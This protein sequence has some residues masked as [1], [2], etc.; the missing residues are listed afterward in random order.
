MARAI[1][2]YSLQLL[3]FSEQSLPLGFG[4]PN[5]PLSLISSVSCYGL[6]HQLILQLPQCPS[7]FLFL[8]VPLV[9]P[10]LAFLKGRLPRVG[11]MEADC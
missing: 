11:S 1:G 6:M 4:L 9:Q 5:G 10:S 7:I 2:S 8:G 3:D